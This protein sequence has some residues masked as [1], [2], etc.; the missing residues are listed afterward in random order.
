VCGVLDLNIGNAVLIVIMIMMSMAVCVV[1]CGVL[2]ALSVSTVLSVTLSLSLRLSLLFF[3]SCLQDNALHHH[4]KFT[5]THAS[6]L[7][8]LLPLP[9]YLFQSSSTAPQRNFHLRTAISQLNDLL[10]SRM[11][12]KGHSSDNPDSVYQG[13][14]QGRLT[15]H[16]VPPLYPSLP[17]YF[18]SP[19]LSSSISPSLSRSSVPPF[20]VHLSLPFSFISPSLSRSSIPPFLVHLSLPFSFVPLLLSSPFSFLS[21][22]D[23]ASHIIS[24]T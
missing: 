14:S 4:L 9:M 13:D 2:A 22:T 11:L 3:F 20:L 21:Y 23:S 16:M 6:Y 24:I 10:Y 1:W 12:S 19:S 8:V 15:A 18:F 5:T 7:T 17:L